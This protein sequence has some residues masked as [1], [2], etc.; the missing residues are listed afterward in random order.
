VIPSVPLPVP[1]IIVRPDAPA[2]DTPLEIR[3]EHFPPGAEVTVR[4]GT[5]DLLGRRW[6][7]RAAFVADEDGAVDIA[8]QAPLAG[9]YR[10]AD[11][12]GLIWSMAEDLSGGIVEPPRD[13]PLP[14]APMTIA[15]E[16]EGM[17]GIDMV[18]DR[19]RQPVGVERA[20]VR[21]RGLVGTL[22][23]PAHGGP[24]PGVILLGGGE[25]GMHEIDAALLAAHGFAVLALAYFGVEGVPDALVDV[26]LEYFA[27]AVSFLEGNELVRGDRLSIVGS[28]R[29]G[30]AALLVASVDARIK[31]AVSVV[32]S[33]VMTQGIP[34]ADTLLEMIANHASAWTQDGRPLAFL[35]C[36][37]PSELADQIGDEE[38]VELALAYRDGLADAEAVAAA[39]IPVERI[40]GPVLLLSSGR[41][42]T[43]PCQAL[44]EVAAERLRQAG[45]P[46]EQVIYEGAGHS[47]AP[48]PYG[49]ATELTT[50][51]P[52]RRSTTGRHLRMAHGGTPEANA[53]AR[54][55]GWLRIRQFLSEHLGD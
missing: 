7:S 51:G 28:S 30:E 6:A 15:A 8:T 52:E 54:A 21:S 49:P 3:L 40:N 23:T 26:P 12:M 46:F 14:P 29:G 33:G 4:A 13:D 24:H 18:F 31:A 50:P 5:R 22:F 53:A 39:S 34:N 27:G 19:L 41:D 43:W 55:D 32:G 16:V 37:V 20:R 1:R 9:S 10:G 11:P 44:T 45:R 38:P 25:G 2:L 35:P 42:K 36:T 17:A 48:P 47:I